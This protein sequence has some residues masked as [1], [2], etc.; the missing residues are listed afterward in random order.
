MTLTSA[1]LTIQSDPHAVDFYIAAG[2]R[3][4]G[5]LESGSVANRFL[6]LL[7]IRIG[8]ERL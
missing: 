2:A 5:V 4:I 3:Q 8:A 6:P 1:R 7:E